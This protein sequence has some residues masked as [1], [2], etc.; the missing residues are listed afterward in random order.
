MSRSLTVLHRGDS[1][2]IQGVRIFSIALR[3]MDQRARDHAGTN[4]A[5]ER[6]LPSTPGVG[7]P[8]AIRHGQE[9]D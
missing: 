6:P 5:R 8:G 9:G 3:R 4:L 1:E 7:S 2:M